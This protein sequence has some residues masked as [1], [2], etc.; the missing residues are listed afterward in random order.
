MR[1]AL[2]STLP[3]ALALRAV[4]HW[5]ILAGGTDFYP[6]LVDAPI[7]ADVLDISGL[8]ALSNIERGTGAWRIGALATW[9]DLLAADLPSAF[10][11]LKLAAREIGSLQIQNA[12]SIA[13]N[14]CNASPAADGV[15]PLLILDARV[16][17]QS[18]RGLREIALEDFT[19]G[20]RQTVLQADEIMTAI[21]IP[22][23]RCTG[24]SH[25]IK[26]GARKYLVISI[27]M[28]A[29]LL[30]LDPGGAI[31]TA[32]LAIGSCSATA[33][34]LHALE[35]A[36][37]G[38]SAPTAMVAAID[39][40]DFTELSP[41]DDIRASRAYRDT[42]ALELVKRAVLTCYAQARG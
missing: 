19:L 2:P 21:V 3:E 32:R 38:L 7:S 5:Q 41:I 30:E 20:N 12:A 17:L 31:K 34:H 22:H 28:V 40:A 1:Y 23:E 9:T 37:Q 15:P 11:A 35:H 8:T 29:A 14:L 10:N 13:G 24:A 42:A 25:F 36:L 27:A 18:A 16:E 33:C 39:A 26:L 6:A 4:G